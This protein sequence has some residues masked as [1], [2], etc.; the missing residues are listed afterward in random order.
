M[1]KR[2][3][4]RRPRFDFDPKAVRITAEEIR[5]D[6]LYPAPARRADRRR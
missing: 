3:P 5:A 1:K 4:S 2:R 6:L